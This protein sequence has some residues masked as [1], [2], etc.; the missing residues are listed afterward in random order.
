MLKSIRSSVVLITLLIFAHVN[1]EQ[2]LPDAHILIN[3]M[4][5][6]SHKLNY[7]GIFMYR[8]QNQIT[9]MRI[10]H[11]VDE[12]GVTEKLISLT[13]H[14]R[15]VIRTDEQV[16]CYFPEKNELVID[17]S[18]IGKLVSSYLP[19]PIE[20][21]SGF[22]MFEIAGENRIAGKEAWIVNIRPKDEY[23]YGY[24]LWIDKESK[25][26]LKSD[27]KN[28]DGVSLEQVMFAQIEIGHFIDDELLKP[29][30]KF[31]NPILVNN[32]QHGEVLDSKTKLSWQMKSLPAGFNISEHAKQ[33]MMTSENPVEH[34][35]YS[36][37]LAMVSVFVEK[38]GNNSK[39]KAGAA[40]FGGV[41][42]FATEV[43]GYQVTAVGEV[44][45][46]TVKLLANSIQSVQ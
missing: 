31:A 32:I 21:V 17:E 18:R 10:I 16:K 12:D 35:I 30:Y 34:I 39:L 1:A 36:D 28:K 22:Y 24:Q 19:N 41:N 29:T 42:T 46:K 25:L 6:A 8:L 11:K 13:G 15:E 27:L 26:L 23:R 2:T 33:I 7:D 44:P 40:R 3:E 9:S 43:N 4:S 45:E 38:L 20:K 5:D 14:P 37:G